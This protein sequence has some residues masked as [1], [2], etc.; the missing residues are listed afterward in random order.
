MH[1]VHRRTR[2]VFCAVLLAAA[3][4]VALPVN[5]L[6]Q[7]F[8]GG[9]SGTVTD[10]SG[11]V[12]SGAQITVV[13]DA[14]NTTYKA[15]S[16]SAGEFSF[17]NMPVSSYTITVIASGFEKLKIDKVRRWLSEPGNDQWLLIFDN[18]DDPHLPGIRSPTGYD[19]RSFFPT[20]SQ[21]SIII[22]S[23]STKLTFSKQLKLQKLENVHTSVA[24]LSQRSGRD[25]SHG[26]AQ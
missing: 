1:M 19:I 11:A 24:I 3:L 2:S 18:Y 25:L 22:T 4:V 9:I 7:T 14:T 16:S 13:D 15:I 26:E 6:G 10:Q 23:R 20:R 5:S 17:S 21:G 8:R 12:V